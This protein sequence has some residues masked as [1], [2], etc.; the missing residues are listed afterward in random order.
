M[1]V[2]QGS[3]FQYLQNYK[4]GKIK[5]GIGIGNNLDNYFR[6]KKGEITIILGHDNVGKTFW[7]V[8]YMLS[9]ALIND[10]TFC[11]WSGENTS[12]QIL[13]DMIQ[14]YVGKPFKQIHLKTI[15]SAYNHLNQY[16][17]FVDNKKLYTPQEL[18]EIFDSVKCDVCFIDPFTGLNREISH[19]ANYDFLNQSRVFC[20]QT[21]KS[22][23]ISSH[24]NSESGRAG[25]LYAENHEWAGHLKAPLKASIEGGKSFLNRTDNMIT[26]H[27]L[28]AHQ[29]MKF[30]T[31]ITVEKI[32]DKETGGQ[33]TNLNEPLLFSYNNGLGFTM[34]GVDN[35]KK[36][37]LQTT[38]TR[39]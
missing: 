25:N 32:K 38:Q 6:L 15:Q 5:P 33:L 27:R 28:V 26:I 4:E 2:T 12:G 14:M 20:N 24:P 7:F 11:I 1:L 29:V 35:L 34:Q 31:M 8:Y 37:R 19:N 16:F 3:E 23:F 13:R 21:K 39:I 36:Y 18:F 30:E 22:L 9:Q 10:K 17:T